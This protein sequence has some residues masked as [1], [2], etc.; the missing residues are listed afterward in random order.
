MSAGSLARLRGVIDDGAAVLGRGR[1]SILLYHRVTPGRDTL[2]P[3]EAWAD[4]FRAKMRLLRRCCNVL[5]LEEASLRLQAGTLP[6][7]AVSVTFDDGYADNHDVALPILQQE[8]VHATFFIATGYLD[9]GRMW[10]DSLIETVRRYAGDRLD[11]QP[12]DLGVHDTSGIDQRRA[13][14]DALIGRIKYLPGD[15]RQATVD[16]VARAA[17]VTLPSDLMMRRDQ[18]RALHR[19]GMG[20]GAHTRRH[21]ILAR[22]SAD[23]A[24]DEIAGGKAELEALIDAPVNLFAYPNGKPARDYLREHVEQVRDSGFLAAVS[25]AWGASKRGADAFQLARFTPW[26]VSPARFLARLLLSRRD[27][28]AGLV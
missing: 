10:N 21:P 27:D 14:I 4:N 19:A 26:D 13:A 7:R 6:P 20:I 22:E 8:G 17:G 12:L 18:V 28:P 2:F 1:L 11:L 16:A 24:H 15:E 5:P 3:A 23:A 9:G 25:T